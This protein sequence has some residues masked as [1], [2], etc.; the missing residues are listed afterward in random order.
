MRVTNDIRLALDRKQGTL[1]VLLDLSSA[2][3]TID[4]TVLLNR[5]RMRYGLRGP[6]L[7]WMESYL[8]DR[9]Q[10]VVI[11]QES[12]DYEE[13]NTGVPQGS[14]LGPLL[15]SLY[16][17]P[18]G[19]IIR[20]HGLQFHH[21]ADDLQL[22]LTFELNAQSLLEAMRRLEACICD[23]REWMTSNY[24][25]LNDGKTEFLPIVPTSAKHL[26]EGLTINVG[27]ITVSAVNSVRNLGVHLD[28]HMDMTTNCSMI[29]RA[30]YYHLH[31]VSQINKFLPRKTRER[32]INALVTSRLDYC[33]SLLYGT[34]DKNFARL[35]RV[36]NAAARI[37]MGVPKRDSITPVLKDLHWLPVCD[38][39]RFKLLVLVH[40]AVN[41]CGPTYLQELVSIHVPA[42]ALR[43]AGSGLL[44]RQR[45]R[46][47]FGDASFVVAAAELWNNLPSS[48]R[49]INSESGF[50]QA[51][52]THY[53]NAHF[54]AH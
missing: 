12:S 33:N 14:V 16:V 17:Q 23:I 5:L 49:Q 7:Q 45:T 47:K 20:R 27:G 38:R 21:Y 36:Q 35:Q 37:I 32:V 1:L 40:R 28:K 19:D 10:R 48:L 52:K 34:I 11:G 53:F 8:Q 18:V 24:L 46:C 44:A 13:L 29:I 3:D 25:K 2:F 50:K 31:H 54:N 15:F 6:A 43:S 30:C 4:H 42:R 51:L 9:K 26:V 41:N 39:A 22:M